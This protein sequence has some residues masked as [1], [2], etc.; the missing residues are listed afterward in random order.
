MAKSLICKDCDTLLKNVKEATEHNVITGHSNFEETT[1]AV[2]TVVCTECGKPCRNDTEKEMHTRGTGHTSFVDKT[3]EAGTID[4]ASQMKAV[5]AEMMEID[6]DGVTGAGAGGSGGDG[7]DGAPVEMVP[8]VVDAAML[9]ELQAM[10]FEANRA[11]RALHFSGNS[12][13][14]GALNWLESNE[15]AI[16]LDEELLVAK[17]S[18]KP[19]AGPKLSPEESRKKIEEQMKKMK[20]KREKEEKETQKLRELER[21][22]S[23]KEMLIVKQKADEADRKRALDVSC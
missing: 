20:E 11:T 16:D 9:T 22:R 10:G 21:I 2:K 4:T 19:P 18:A 6:G 8:A 23:G 13:L 1:I 17:G 3:S 15:S 12:T 14:E 5:K 7:G